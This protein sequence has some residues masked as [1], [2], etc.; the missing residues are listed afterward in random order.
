MSH[1]DALFL[2]ILKLGIGTARATD[3]GCEPLLK[4]FTSEW[5][6]LMD[7]ATNQGVAAVANDG[8]QVL[9]D[10]RQKDMVAAMESPI[11]WKMWVIENAGVL[12]LYEKK[13]VQQ[14]KVISDVAGLLAKNGIKMM[15]FKGQAN[16]SF[17]P[18]SLHRAPGDIDCYLFGD[19]AAGDELLAANGASID[20]RWYRHSKIS[21][22]GETIENHRVMGH[23]RGSRKKQE[24]ENE[25]R[26][27]VQGEG[28]NVIEGC[29]KALMPTAQFNA[30]FLT[31][32]GL[33]HFLTEGLR[34]KQVLDWAVFLKEK[35]KE[36]D[37]QVFNAFCQ[38]YQLDRFAAVMNYIAV[39]HLGVEVLEDGIIQDVKYAE[40][41]MESTLHDS[42]YL[43]NSGKSDWVVRWLLVK[44]MLTKDKWKYKDLA[45]EN[46]WIHLWEKI[47][48][49]LTKEEE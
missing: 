31:Y 9:L 26:L 18:N 35:Q 36:V 1:L 11:E 21:Y 13:N 25:F 33:H 37:W 42:D 28:L 15:I 29:G 20:N 4:L 38:K 22:K 30:C 23:T 49:F 48:G 8:L 46:V 39:H 24:M 34:M 45:Q 10:E 44:N 7:L 32:H 43:F 19:D 41:I 14:Q 17:Y 2:T 5:R 27:M 6:E 12:T 3:T 40:K 16:G 47:K